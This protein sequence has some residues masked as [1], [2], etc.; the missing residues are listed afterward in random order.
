ML[1]CKVLT[2]CFAFCIP[3][4]SPMCILNLHK[5]TLSSSEYFQNA[6]S[7][8]RKF[9]CKIVHWFWPPSSLAYWFSPQTCVR[10]LS[11]RWISLD[12]AVENNCI[13]RI[14]LMKNYYYSIAHCMRRTQYE[15]TSVELTMKKTSKFLDPQSS[16]G[17]KYP[18]KLMSF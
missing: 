9:K 7:Y 12:Y 8:F 2:F 11:I 18:L 17:Q 5:F 1:Q 3:N 13:R 4:L 14:S 16:S 6:F 10:M 15:A